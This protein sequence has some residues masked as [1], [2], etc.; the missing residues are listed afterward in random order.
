MVRKTPTDKVMVSR[1]R[2][3]RAVAS[4]S[5]IETGERTVVIE[6]RLKSRQRRF[7]KLTLAF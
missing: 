5:A 6:K 1:E 3:L 7:A 2:I 4:S